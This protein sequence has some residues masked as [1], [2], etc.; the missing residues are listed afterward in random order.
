MAPWLHKLSLHLA[1]PPD[2]FGSSE[3]ES[4][5]VQISDMCVASPTTQKQKLLGLL[6][7]WDQKAQKVT[8][9]LFS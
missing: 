6:D 7:T 4:Q 2:R 8:C 5:G 9:T 1:P 3:H